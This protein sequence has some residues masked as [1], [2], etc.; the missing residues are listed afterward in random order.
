VLETYA[1]LLLEGRQPRFAIG[2]ER[3]Y[4]F[5]DAAVDSMVIEVLALLRHGVRLSFKLSQ[6]VIIEYWFDSPVIFI[7]QRLIRVFQ[8]AAEVLEISL[9][10]VTKRDIGSAE[11]LLLLVLGADVMEES[12]EEI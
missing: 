9:W 3:I 1:T 6:Q 5:V 12:M 11:N 8:I 7:L 2:A 10:L 4:D